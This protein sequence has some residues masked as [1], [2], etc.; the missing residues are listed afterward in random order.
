MSIQWQSWPPEPRPVELVEQ[1]GYAR[2]LVGQS[3]I[4]VNGEE[5]VLMQVDYNGMDIRRTYEHVMRFGERGY[6]RAPIDWRIDSISIR[7]LE[8][9]EPLA[10]I[11]V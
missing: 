9:T 3:R 10:V 4:R 1:V 5:Y 6:H 11:S 8:S 7:R 2:D